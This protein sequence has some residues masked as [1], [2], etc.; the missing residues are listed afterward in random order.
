MII[1]KT[2]KTLTKSEEEH[3]LSSDI[4][5]RTCANAIWREGRIRRV[6]EDN[7][8]ILQC[9][10]PVFF[11]VTWATQEPVEFTNCD[12]FKGMNDLT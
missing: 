5:C 7:S 4:V 11:T 3:E 2:L 1:S 6:Q 10:C 12:G 9:Y 8:N